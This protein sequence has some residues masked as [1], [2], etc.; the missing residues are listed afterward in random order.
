MKTIS[1][2]FFSKKKKKSIKK[3]YVCSKNSIVWLMKNNKKHL[4]KGGSSTPG[5]ESKWN[6][7]DVIINC[8][9]VPD[10]TELVG[11][12]GFGSVRKLSC[13]GEEH[14]CKTN[15]LADMHKH[16][17]EI[18]TKLESSKS[19]INIICAIDTTKQI[20]LERAEY[21]LFTF[22][23]NETNTTLILDEKSV[24]MQNIIIGMNYMHSKNII[25]NDIKSENL[26]IMPV[27]YSIKYCDFGISVDTTL[28]SRTDNIDTVLF[29]GTKEFITPEAFK[30]NSIK[31]VNTYNLK[32]KD[33]WCLGIV[34]FQILN[35]TNSVPYDFKQLEKLAKNYTNVVNQTGLQI[36]LWLTS[37]LLKPDPVERKLP[38]NLKNDLLGISSTGGQKPFNHLTTMHKNSK[39]IINDETKSRINELRINKIRLTSMK[40]RKDPDGM[41]WIN[42]FSTDYDKKKEQDNAIA[43]NGNGRFKLTGK[44]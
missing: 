16:E 12:G 33:Y 39:F 22:L 20:I 21:S 30:F 29:Q 32:K 19:I 24:L 11:K 7:R 1:I 9:D 28:G 17:V 4:V 5:E 42:L 38:N 41:H 14:V 18:F 40:T 35:V 31:D 6:C 13:N 10:N 26:L 43:K 25:H 44:I 27:D 2:T 23:K 3:D 15:T 36:P 37:S 34:M 8:L